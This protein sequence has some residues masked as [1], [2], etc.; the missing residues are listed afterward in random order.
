MFFPVA[1]TFLTSFKT[2]VEI[3]R[4]PPSIFPDSFSLYGYKIVFA[5]HLIKQLMNSIFVSAETILL[6]LLISILSG[7][8]FARANFR[9]K[10]IL[11]YILVGTQMIPGLSNIITLYMIGSR[12]RMLNTHRFIVV[13]Y[14]AG[15]APVCTWLMKAYFEQIPA[16]LDEAALMDGCSRLGILWHIILPLI[17]TGMVACALMVFVNA[18]NE[19]LVALTMISRTNLKTF[20]VGL[21]A[22]LMENNISWN[23]VSCATILGLIPILVLFIGFQKYF[24]EGMTSGA[25][26]A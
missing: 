12:L 5:S 11:L 20:P 15:S 25:I 1:W 17:S 16:S 18:W 19:F 8:A 13:I 2:E 6:T 22:F 24:V 4:F 14:A 3:Y 21:Q 9:G 10:N 26:K 7:F 23:V